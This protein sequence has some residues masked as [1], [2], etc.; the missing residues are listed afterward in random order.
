MTFRILFFV[1]M[2]AAVF[3]NAPARAN[4]VTNGG[5]ETG[6]FTGWDPPGAGILIDQVFPADGLYDAAFS[7]T[8]TLSQS[9][10]TTPGTGYSLTFSLL[11]ESGF[12]LD[13]FTAAFGSFS[14]TV[15]GDTALPYTSESF[16]VPG[17]DI[18]GSSTLL[19]F[20]GTNLFADWNLDDVSVV[21]T[22]IPEP[23]S[24]MLLMAAGVLAFSFTARRRMPRG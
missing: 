4:L 8:G 7:D 21:S 3:A 15:S 16:L 22:A 2:A 10:A 23:S 18:T 20:Q 11:D 14:V 13:S 17:S 12:P 19:S 1:G 5:F 9:I 6:D 24:G